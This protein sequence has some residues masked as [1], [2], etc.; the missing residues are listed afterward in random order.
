MARKATKTLAARNTTLLLRTHLITLTLHTLFLTLSFLISRRS[1]TPYI[2]LTSPTLLIEFYLD[3]LGR[4]RY[5]PDGTLRSA[6]EDLDARGLTEFL[7]DV[8][9]WTWGCMGVVCVFGDRAWWLWV[10]VPGYSA[11]LGYKTFMGFRSGGMMGMDAGAGVA[12]GGGGVG[13]SK[14]QKKME[15]RGQRVKYR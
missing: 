15:K 8:L 12:E 1:L 10:A 2:L 3:R 4:P 5:N 7:W 9:Y 11:W 6:G 14:R 13:E